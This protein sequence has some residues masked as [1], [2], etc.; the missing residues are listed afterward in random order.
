[1]PAGGP[2]RSRRASVA[3]PTVP[4]QGRV[5]QGTRD[6]ANAVADC[7]GISLGRYLEILVE[8]DELDEHGRPLWAAQAGLLPRKDEALPGM[9][10]V[11][12]A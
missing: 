8:R 4:L 7:L 3:G 11:H 2:G 5:P 9:D 1:M 6:R 10:T 12:A